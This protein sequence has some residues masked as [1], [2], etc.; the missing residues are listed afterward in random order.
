MDTLKLKTQI[1]KELH[2]FVTNIKE[3]M[4]DYTVLYVRRNMPHIDREQLTQILDVVRN[5]I[6]DSYFTQIDSFMTK[7]NV[8]IE[9]TVESETT[10]KSKKSAKNSESARV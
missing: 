9:E 3:H 1:E 4:V 8:T 2:G 7:M 5:G 6:E 10:T